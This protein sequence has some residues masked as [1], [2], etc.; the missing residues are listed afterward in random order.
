[1][2]ATAA[3]FRTLYSRPTEPVSAEHCSHSS[4]SLTCEMVLP[5]IQLRKTAQCEHDV[6]QAVCIKSMGI[7][8]LHDR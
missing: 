5:P 2:E 7:V 8:I 6:R 3:A 1:M 4:Q